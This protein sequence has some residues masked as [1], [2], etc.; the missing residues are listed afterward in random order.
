MDPVGSI[1]LNKLQQVQQILN[2]SAANAGL[3]PASFSAL[4][5]KE[6]AIASSSSPL[7]AN[8]QQYDALIKRAAA[9]NGLDP[10]LVRAVIKAESSFRKDAVSSA[11]AQGLMQ[12]MP[13]TARG[14]GVKDSFDPAENIN[15]GTKYLSDLIS[16]FG[17]TRLALAAYN[18]GPGRVKRL[19]ITDANNAFEYS[20]LSERVRS[21]VSRVLSYY[22]AYA[23]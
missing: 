10:N 23:G 11:G 22:E 5:L 15:G 20:K 12:L 9:A 18:T 1:Y 17:D 14:L 3:E 4:M 19:N 8:E 16:R 7:S 21:Y 6:E 2:S 13:A